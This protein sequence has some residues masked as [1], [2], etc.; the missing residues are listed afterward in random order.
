MR[1]EVEN[2]LEDAEQQMLEYN[3]KNLYVTDHKPV[4]KKFST[5]SDEEDA[6]YYSYVQQLAE[7]NKQPMARPGANR[8]DSGRFE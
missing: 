1:Q 5:L 8:F 4:A 7:Y 2:F 3:M 6:E